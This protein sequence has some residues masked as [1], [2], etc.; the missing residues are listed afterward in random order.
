MM[1][2]GPHDARV[3]L[4]QLEAF[5]SVVLCGT[6]SKAAE[7]MCVSQPAVSRLLADL[8]RA[9]GFQVCDRQRRFQ[10]THEG[11]LLYLEVERAFV[12]MDKIE[13]R[14]TDI[15]NFRTG[16]LR[17]AASP[18]LSLG[19]M[20]A[21]IREFK[22]LYPGVTISAQVRPSQGVTEWAASAQVDIGFAALP[23]TQSGVD[24]YAYEGLP[25]L[26]V[27]PRG[28]KLTARRAISP[29]LLRGEHIIALGPESSLRSDINHAFVQ[30]GCDPSSAIETTMS[31]QAAM[32]VAQGLGV[33]VIDPFSALAF[34][35]RDLVLKPFQPIVTYEF[36]RVMAAHIAPSR[37][38]EAFIAI[39]NDQVR[40]I[41]D[42]VRA[43]FRAGGLKRIT[44]AI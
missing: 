8:E 30:A 29:D 42:D 36:T 9:I 21:V 27:L 6:V 3:S 32:F 37:V 38:S 5:R 12:G 10:L 2:I 25:V 20:P 13:Q 33:A 39:A 41:G 7:R 26:C 17:I 14:A 44:Q 1:E 40:R 15:R 18:A 43:I 16:H 28:H 19:L 34:R 23:I 4:R 31:A 22:A 24:E 11:K 35:S